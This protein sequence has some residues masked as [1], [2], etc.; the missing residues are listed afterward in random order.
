MSAT[1][2]PKTADQVA[3]EQASQIK[4]LQDQLAAALQA[5]SDLAPKDALPAAP[6]TPVIYHSSSPFIKVPIMRAPGFCDF[7][8]FINGSLETSDPAVIAS[9]EATIKTQNSGFYHGKPPETDASR[10]AV[11][12]DLANAA[13]AA[14]AKM[15][16]A[17]EKTA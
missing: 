12:A 10:E 11:A 6:V 3:A 2:V 13:A 16:A 4:T 9:M 17:G 7:V 14:H 8:Q 5:L 15:L 1:P